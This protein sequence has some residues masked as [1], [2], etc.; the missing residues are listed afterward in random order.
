MLRSTVSNNDIPLI[1]SKI[2]NYIGVWL[3]KN[4][5]KKDYA[6]INQKLHKI[7]DS[8]EIFSDFT[9][10]LLY[11]NQ[12]RPGKIFFIVSHEIGEHLIPL[13]L[14]QG[15]SSIEYIYIYCS[16]QSKQDYWNSIQSDQLR[17]AFST[18]E[19][20]IQQIK[21]DTNAFD[22]NI[23]AALPTPPSSTTDVYNETSTTTTSDSSSLCPNIVYA[24]PPTSLFNGKLKNSSI[25]DLNE[26]SV[27]FIQFQLLVEI[28]LRLEK[29]ERAKTDLISICREYYKD[30]IVEQRKIKQFEEEAGNLSKV[31]YCTEDVEHLYYFRLFISNLHN[32]VLAMKQD[33]L[34]IEMQKKKTMLYRGKCMPISTL[35]NF[36]K[37]IGG[38]VAMKGFLSTTKQKDVAKMF[39][40]AGVSSAG[41]VCV[42]FKL[43]IHSWK[44]CKPSAVIKPEDGA[45][46]DEDEVLFSIG[47]IWRIVSVD[48]LKEAR[49]WCI[50][51]ISCEEENARSIE[52]TN[53]LK[54]QIGETSNLWTLG[55]FLMKMGEYEK[56]EKYY[57]I[58]ELDL[59]LPEKHVDRAAIYNRLGLIRW[60]Q[61]QRSLAIEYFEKAVKA[62]PIN[63]N[64]KN[65][66]GEN[67]QLVQHEHKE[68]PVFFL[69]RR[70]VAGDVTR[71]IAHREGNYDL[72]IEHYNKAISI[73]MKSELAH[74]LELSCVHNNLGAV[75]YVKKNYPQA[76]DYF[77][78][79][80]F[81]IQRLN[82]KHP[83]INEYKENLTC[84]QSQIS[85]RP[86]LN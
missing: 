51:L 19:K 3:D 35:E 77:E 59:N 9:K 21:N 14:S 30:N 44:K 84:A 39:A 22:K 20:L 74:L 8:F 48:E 47:S 10:C 86:R 66:A 36:R 72:A 67:L 70:L 12:P 1:A 34:T 5:N 38:L 63:D 23:T 53:Y 41:V 65:V 82:S 6:P 2:Q 56:A 85:K 43:N 31:M 4:C 29:S 52:L 7:F 71:H 27:W 15:T 75:E 32:Q 68:A 78:K 18:A 11:I 50:Q 62:A 28:L 42:L 33:K 83:W 64:I 60:E 13:I 79:A 80:I 37:N 24:V 16:D 58:L 61:G 76:K 45:M 55:D 54:E 81:T 26:D 73:M 25:R 49:M 17:G 69:K 40:G 46:K 57:A